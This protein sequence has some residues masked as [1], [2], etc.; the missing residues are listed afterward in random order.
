MTDFKL[1][2]QILQSNSMVFLKGCARG[3]AHPAWQ[4]G[5]ECYQGDEVLGWL[6]RYNYLQRD[7]HSVTEEGTR[8]RDSVE[9]TSCE[10]PG[11]CSRAESPL[12]NGNTAAPWPTQTP[13]D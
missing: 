8:N 3:A 6:F 12:G 5:M 13:A 7:V 2:Q 11:Q 10:V 1:Q 9:G 4:Q